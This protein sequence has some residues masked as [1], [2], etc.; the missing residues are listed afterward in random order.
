[1]LQLGDHFRSVDGR[2]RSDW[3]RIQR[4]FARQ[5]HEN[6]RREKLEE[7]LENNAAAFATGMVVATQ[8]QIEAFELK[9]DRYEE[10]TVA[11]LIENQEQLDAVNARIFA[12]LNQA[13]VLDDGRRV[14]RTEDGTQV[15][16]EFGE[17]VG[18]DEIDPALIGDEFPT[19]EAFQPLLTERNALDAERAQ[20]L[21]FQERL[22]QARDRIAEGDIGETEL[23]EL[24]A[25]LAELAPPAVRS[26]VPGMAAPDDEP[27]LSASFAKSAEI[28]QMPRISTVGTVPTPMQ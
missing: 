8:M 1:M 9:L 18:P 5:R 3:E 2:H 28:P 20:L 12:M 17:E 27:P 7:R 22:D 11:A 19:W 15:F 24:D 6:E 10:A 21:D 14:F 16:D 13:Y 25:E 4:Q 23:D 26:R